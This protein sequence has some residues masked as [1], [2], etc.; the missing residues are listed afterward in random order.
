MTLFGRVGC[1]KTHLRR[2]S[3]WQLMPVSAYK[4]NFPFYGCRLT[5][6]NRQSSWLSKLAMVHPKSQELC[7]VVL[8]YVRSIYLA[9]GEPRFA[10]AALVAFFSGSNHIAKYIAIRCNN[11]VHILSWHLRVLK[12]SRQHTRRIGRGLDIN[13]SSWRH[14]PAHPFVADLLRCLIRITRRCFRKHGLWHSVLSRL[15]YLRL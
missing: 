14:P 1:H 7:G 8:L 13:T 15:L 2:C 12:K 6:N 11:T 4:Q 9:C 10:W 3:C 5:A